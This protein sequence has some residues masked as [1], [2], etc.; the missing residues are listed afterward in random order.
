MSPAKIH[1]LRS[2]ALQSEAQIKETA[3]SHATML[4]ITPYD[5][6]GSPAFVFEMMEPERPKVDGAMLTFMR[7][8]VCRLFRGGR[9]M[10]LDVAV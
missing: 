8:L 10:V 6:D 3:D 1:P 4:G 2:A 7:N 5:R 9:G